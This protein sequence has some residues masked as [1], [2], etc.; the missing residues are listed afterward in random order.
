[1]D[2]KKSDGENR[3]KRP[4]TIPPSTPQGPESNDMLVSPEYRNGPYP[5]DAEDMPAGEGSTVSTHAT[6]IPPVKREAEKEGMPGPD[7][8]PVLEKRGQTKGKE[9]GREQ[10]EP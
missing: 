6:G 3:P 7:A 5:G 8:G 1:M 2:T 9:D 4:D 10:H